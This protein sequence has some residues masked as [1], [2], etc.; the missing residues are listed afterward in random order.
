MPDTAVPPEFVEVLHAAEGRLDDS[1][2]EALVRADA[3]RCGELF[4]LVP[5]IRRYATAIDPSLHPRASRE[6]AHQVLNAIRGDRERALEALSSKHP[7]WDGALRDA[8]IALDLLG[9]DEDESPPVDALGEAVSD[10]RPRFLVGDVLTRGSFGVIVEGY[11]RVM[12]AHGAPQA[13]VV[14]K[15]LRVRAEHAPWVEEAQ[16]ASAIDHPCSIEVR[17]QGTID[18][19]HGFV[20][21]ERVRGR[22]LLAMAAAG[23]RLRPARALAAM[24]ELC[25]ALA[26]LHAAGFAHGDLSPANVMIDGQGR[27]RLVDYGLSRPL[28]PEL[29]TADLVRAGE[30]LQWIALGFVP[31]DP[32]HPRM[33]L[34]TVRATMIR[35]GRDCRLWPTNAH[36]LA[37]RLLRA[38]WSH[39][40]RRVWILGAAVAALVTTALL[41]ARITRLQA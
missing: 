11:D 19:R 7:A 35:I 25:E 39:E 37:S 6:V 29:E 8:S 24:A 27:M 28:T 17:A 26:E 38:E 20:V 21:F 23:E 4:E 22:S 2:L 40:Q 12:A 1:A 30:L 10:G 32:R 9:V 34:P 13:A 16:R 31:R 41:V 5:T 18:A 36:H 14:I 3:R 33:L 15:F